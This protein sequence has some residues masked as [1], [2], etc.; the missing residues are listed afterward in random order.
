YYAAGIEAVD[1]VRALGRDEAIDF[2]AQGDGEYAVAHS[3][4]A[5]AGLAEQA[6]ARSRALGVPCRALSRDE[7]A[8]RGYA[9]PACFGAVYYPVGFG[10]NPLKFVRGLARAAVRKGAV[11]HGGT[12]VLGWEKAGAG[13]RLATPG[14][15]LSAKRVVIATNGYTR[16]GLHP[17][18]DGV[19]LPAIS[20]IIVTRPLT[21]DE[22]AAHRWTTENPIWDSRHLFYYYRMLK[23]GRFLLG[24]RGNTTARPEDEVAMRARLTADLGRIWPA[25]RA[26]PITHS[27]R[28]FVCLS[29]ALAPNIG[30]MTDDSSVAYAVGYHGSGVAWA[31]WSG[32][33]AARLI[34][35]NA[36]PGD[37]LPAVVG[38][39]LS[40]FPL[41]AFR[42]WYLRA[43]YAVY[44]VKDRLGL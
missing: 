3:P 20:N 11:I 39:P 5:A 37:L 42:V 1:L 26:V 38:Q 17:G 8:E 2:D 31:N 23:D 9:G 12:P 10:L 33:A 32:R 16:D 13:H 6:R 30:V 18:M 25:W 21:L 36:R 43:A 40:R 22:R 29:R 15:T 28:G 24:A 14:G 34:A 35:G 4:R 7:F 44:A 41:A 19:L 27:W